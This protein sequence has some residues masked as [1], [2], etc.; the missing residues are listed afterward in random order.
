VSLFHGALVAHLLAN[1]G[2]YEQQAAV[3]REGYV[4]DI[5]V[6]DC[7]GLLFLVHS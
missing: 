2:K 7:C 6:V 5:S 1:N 3:K 4:I